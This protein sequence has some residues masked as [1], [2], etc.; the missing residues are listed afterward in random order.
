MKLLQG[1]EPSKGNW[2]VNASQGKSQLV[3]DDEN[4][5]KLKLYLG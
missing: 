3:N 1:P 2:A 4:A 5:E